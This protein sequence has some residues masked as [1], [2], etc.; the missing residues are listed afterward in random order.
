M[1]SKKTVNGWDGRSALCIF[2]VAGLCHER[3]RLL[4]V[5]LISV[6]SVL[7][8]YWYV[9]AMLVATSKIVDHADTSTSE[10]QNPRIGIGTI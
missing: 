4:D 1:G 3:C 8:H 7:S 5:R 2:S 10:A 9:T 6:R